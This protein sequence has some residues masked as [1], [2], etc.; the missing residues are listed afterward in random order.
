MDTLMTILIGAGK[1]TIGAVL[2]F[3]FLSAIVNEGL[4]KSY[5]DSILSRL[6]FYYYPIAV[7][8]A[9]CVGLL[10]TVFYVLGS[11]DLWVNR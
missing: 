1:F 8:V 9:V 4:E 5:T 2:L 7:L 3:P 6:Y 10:L 11:H